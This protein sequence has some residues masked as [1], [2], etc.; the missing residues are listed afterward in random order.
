MDAE[1]KLPNGSLGS[2]THA[3]SCDA[4]WLSKLQ[5]TSAK[6]ALHAIAGLFVEELSDAVSTY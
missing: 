1:M 6:S 2:W 5:S 3:T 4:V